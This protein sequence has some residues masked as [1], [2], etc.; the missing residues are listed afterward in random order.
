MITTNKFQWC[1]FL[2]IWEAIKEK[3][4]VIVNDDIENTYTDLNRTNIEEKK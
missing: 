1:N 2:N 4:Y 3:Y